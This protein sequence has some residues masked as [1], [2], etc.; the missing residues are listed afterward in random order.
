MNQETINKLHITTGKFQRYL[1]SKVDRLCQA[2]WLIPAALALGRL[3]L[4]RL[5]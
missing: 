4:S 1:I 5:A 3:R 2:R